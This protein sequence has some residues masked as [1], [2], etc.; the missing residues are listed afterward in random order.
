MKRRPASPRRFFDAST[1]TR[2]LGRTANLQRILAK[3][4]PY[5]A[6][7]ML[8]FTAAIRQ[9]DLGAMTEPRLRALATI[10]T[11]MANECNYCTTHTSMYG[12]GSRPH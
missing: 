12:P 10:K 6:R 7:W 2:F 5:L 9:P 11:S 1:P 4:A 3:H 8:G